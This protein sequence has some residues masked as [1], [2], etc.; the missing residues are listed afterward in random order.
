MHAIAG[1][2]WLPELAHHVRGQ[3]PGRHVHLVLEND[4]N[5]ASLLQAGYDAQWNDD[6]H[7]VLHH[8][9]TGEA[10]GYYADYTTRPCLLYTSDAADE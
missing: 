4:D 10:H 9:L 7:H 5:R 6:A 3:L 2:E 8:L 1:H